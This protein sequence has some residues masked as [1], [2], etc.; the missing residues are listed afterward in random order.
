MNRYIFS[1]NYAKG[2]LKNQKKFLVSH[3]KIHTEKN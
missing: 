2:N 1:F 3:N